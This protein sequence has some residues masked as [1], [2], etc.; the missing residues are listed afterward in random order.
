MAQLRK[1]W[2]EAD[3]R[4]EHLRRQPGQAED[5]APSPHGH[6]ARFPHAVTDSEAVR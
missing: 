5:S 1:Y 4:C 6:L 2:V 3:A